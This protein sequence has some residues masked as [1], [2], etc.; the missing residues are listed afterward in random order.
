MIAYIICSLIGAAIAIAAYTVIQRIVLNGRK[1][2]IIAQAEP[3]S[4]RYYAGF[5]G[6]WH[7][8][9]ATHL[10]VSLRCMHLDLLGRNCTLYA[11]GGILRASSEGAEWWETVRKAGTM[12]RVLGVNC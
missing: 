9:A 5:A 2:E 10:Y 11:G 6:P 12:M 8:E 7:L 1:N 4:R 3:H